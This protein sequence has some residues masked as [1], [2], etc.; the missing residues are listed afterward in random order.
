MAKH[1]RWFIQFVIIPYSLGFTGPAIQSYSHVY[2][3]VP[4][5]VPASSSCFFSSP[6]SLLLLTK[7]Q[8]FSG[9]TYRRR[10][11]KQKRCQ[12]YWAKFLKKHSSNIIQQ[13]HST[14]LLAY[15]S[16][17]TRDKCRRLKFRVWDSLWKDGRVSW[18]WGR[19]LILPP[20]ERQYLQTER[21]TPRL[22]IVGGE[23]G[24][25][26]PLALPWLSHATMITLYPFS[27]VHIP[28]R[29]FASLSFLAF[30]LILS[31]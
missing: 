10:R 3:S 29:Y 7:T 31:L 4:V 17:V 22:D 5:P 15:S 9:S 20:T 26:G 2:V 1:K 11:R 27:S 18:A 25:E 16:K 13:N 19:Y 6:S 23:G 21:F 8:V 14:Y 28:A 12:T 30:S 24:G